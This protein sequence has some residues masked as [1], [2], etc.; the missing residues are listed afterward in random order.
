MKMKKYN[1][2]Q[3]YVA[4][5]PEDV[6]EKLEQ[7]REIVQR[8]APKSQEAISYNMPAYKMNSV[9]VYFAAF[10]NHIGFFQLHPVLKHFNTRLKNTN[11]R[12]AQFNFRL[13]N[14]SQKN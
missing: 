2:V 9:L 14:R 13:I 4:D 12:K 5:F 6:R 8:S 1:D 7:M 3:T 10:K 11:G